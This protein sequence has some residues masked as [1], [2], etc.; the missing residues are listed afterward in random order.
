MFDPQSFRRRSPNETLQSK[1]NRGE[2]TP[3]WRAKIAKHK[4]KSAGNPLRN[5][6]AETQHILIPRLGARNGCCLRNG[7]RKSVAQRS[8]INNFRVNAAKAWEEASPAR[9]STCCDTHH[10]PKQIAERLGKRVLLFFPPS[11]PRTRPLCRPVSGPP[12]PFFGALS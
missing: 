7:A 6:N 10:I 3:V 9:T 2:D 11:A 12:R 8:K 5:R 1:E 4:K